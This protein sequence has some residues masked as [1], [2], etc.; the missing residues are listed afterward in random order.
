MFSCHFVSQ[1]A[2]ERVFVFVMSQ[3]LC[4]TCVRLYTDGTWNIR[5][6]QLRFSSYAEHRTCVP[7]YK[8]DVRIELRTS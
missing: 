5:S 4:G 8:T 6:S 7:L 1:T 3:Y 2:V